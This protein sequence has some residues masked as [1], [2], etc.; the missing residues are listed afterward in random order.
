MGALAAVEQ[1]LVTTL[2]AAAGAVVREVSGI[3]A[4]P[5]EPS[6]RRVLAQAPGLYVAFLGGERRPGPGVQIDS[7]WGVYAIAANAAGSAA[8]R[9]G[10][11][12][13]IGAYDLVELAIATLDRHVVDGVGALELEQ[14]GNL[15][16]DA[17]LDAGRTV[18]GLTFSLP[19]QL[20][21]EIDASGLDDFETFHANWDVPAHGNVEPP[22]PADATA[23]ATDHVPIPQEP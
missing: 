16:S 20:P 2:R 7:R 10:T 9:Q 1:D 5:D 12:S 8:Q 17:F 22:L 18:Y 6:M 23:D 21:G 11:A 13:A 19:M 15:A 4:Q 14:V 3:P